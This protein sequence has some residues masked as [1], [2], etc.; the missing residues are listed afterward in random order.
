M[1]VYEVCGNDYDKAFEIRAQDET[2]TFDSFECAIRALPP[3]CAHCGCRAI[4]HRVESDGRV[5]CYAHCAW[6]GGRFGGV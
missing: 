1:A 5:F 2:H 4:G 6:R 3:I